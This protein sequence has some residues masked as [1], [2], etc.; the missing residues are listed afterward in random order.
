MEI[1]ITVKLSQMYERDPTP[2]PFEEGA[3]ETSGTYCFLDYRK[4]S[5]IEKCPQ[6]PEKVTILET[7]YCQGS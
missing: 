4:V 6:I 3:D 2:L 1:N 7:S 5:E